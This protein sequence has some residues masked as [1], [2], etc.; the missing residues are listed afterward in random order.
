MVGENAAR[1]AEAFRKSAAY[2]AM[3]K[4]YPSLR[5][6]ESPSAPATQPAVV[7][8]EVEPKPEVS[9][10]AAMATPAK[11]PVTASVPT[12]AGPTAQESREFMDVLNRGAAHL[13]PEQKQLA[14]D[15]Y[16]A[17]KYKSTSPVV[18]AAAPAPPIDVPS[19]PSAESVQ[20]AREAARGVSRMGLLAGQEAGRARTMTQA[21]LGKALA[22][23]TGFEESGEM[24]SPRLMGQMLR[25]PTAV[26]IPSAPVTVARPTSFGRPAATTPG[27]EEHLVAQ[28]IEHL[29]GS[30]RMVPGSFSQDIPGSSIKNITMYPGNNVSVTYKS[31][32]STV[33]PFK[34]HPAYADEL[35]TALQQGHFLPGGPHS[36]G[37][38]IQAGINMGLLR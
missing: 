36:A 18:E 9:P 21:R 20:F 12:G 37:G 15:D 38:F 17:K 10:V 30:K 22:E 29:E 35:K 23:A 19:G 34:A 3:Q 26:E 8:T 14:H 1:K 27:T 4:E 5:P 6:I 2:A 31:D 33:Y 32:P 25:R 28:A 7:L 16:F 13:T 24:A 11:A